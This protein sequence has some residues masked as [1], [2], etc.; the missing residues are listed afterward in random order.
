[1]SQQKAETVHITIIAKRVGIQGQHNLQPTFHHPFL[2]YPVQLLCL[3]ADNTRQ[4]LLAH[5]L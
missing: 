1:M 4:P 3:Q 2:P 5:L